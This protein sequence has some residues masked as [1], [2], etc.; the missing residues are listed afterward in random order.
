MDK[1]GHI[2]DQF[3]VDPE[4]KCMYYLILLSPKSVPLGINLAPSPGYLSSCTTNQA[5][6]V[7]YKGAKS[8]TFSDKISVHFGGAM[9]SGSLK[10]P[11]FVVFSTIWPYYLP[12]LTP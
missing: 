3:L 11:R 1:S 2:L 6:H 5:F 9:S 12:N 10:S 4:F 7:D 8:G